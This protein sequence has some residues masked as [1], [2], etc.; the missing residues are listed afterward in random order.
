MKKIFFITII[1]QTNLF[2]SQSKK[3][4]IKL[5]TEKIDSLKSVIENE[6]DFNYKKELLCFW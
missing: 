2:F 5:L 3:E 6:R 4:Q 1:I